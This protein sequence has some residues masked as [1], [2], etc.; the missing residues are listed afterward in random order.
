M[1]PHTVRNGSQFW[2]GLLMIYSWFKL[3]G[4]FF[5]YGSLPVLAYHEYLIDNI[6]QTGRGECSTWQTRTFEHKKAK[7]SVFST[8]PA[9]PVMRYFVPDIFRHLLERKAR[10]FRAPSIDLRSG[11]TLKFQKPYMPPLSTLAL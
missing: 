5:A 7:N 11:L 1:Q 3:V 2:Q 10:S 6:N 4:R 8:K 9:R